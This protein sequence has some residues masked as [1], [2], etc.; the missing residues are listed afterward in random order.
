MEYKEFVVGTKKNWAGIGSIEVIKKT[1]HFTTF[2]IITKDFKGEPFEITFRR[3]E[4]FTHKDNGW[5]TPSTFT[6][7]VDWKGVEIYAC[8]F[9]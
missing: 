9:E 6:M 8:D 7:G 2:R 4:Q 1:N 3:K 5:L